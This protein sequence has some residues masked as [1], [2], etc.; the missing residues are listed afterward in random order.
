MRERSAHKTFKYRLEPTAAQARQLAKTLLLCHELYNAA[1]GERREAWRMREISLTY[2]QQKAELPGIKEALPEFRDVHSQVLQDVILR[3]ERAFRRF[4]QRVRDGE[5]P[6]YPRFQGRRRY[7]SFTYPQFGNGATLDN[8]F[9]VLS[10]IGRIRVRWSRP[11]AGVPKTA[12]VH[13]EVD[14]WYVCI[15]CVEVPIQPLPDTGKVTGIDLGLKV[16]AICADGTLTE[17]PRY[18]RRAEKEL[19]KAHTRVSRRKRGSK[20]RAKA[21]HNLA[22]KY[23]KVSRQRM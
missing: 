19:K 1:I 17:N 6:G 2:Y 13:R 5:T 7:A 15:A 18:Y 21:A 11:L 12:T 14:G 20:R 10:K 22:R 23:S 8:G 3:A 4:F 9:L 16:F